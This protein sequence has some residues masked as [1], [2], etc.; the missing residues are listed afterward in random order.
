MELVLVYKP[1]YNWVAPSWM[2]NDER[3]FL[4]SEK[5]WPD[6]HMKQIWIS[7][8]IIWISIQKFWYSY[9]PTVFFLSEK[10]FI[11]RATRCGFGKCH[12]PGARCD[13]RWRWDFGKDSPHAAGHHWKVAS[14][15]GGTRRPRG[16]RGQGWWSQ[17][18][19][20][21]DIFIGNTIRVDAWHGLMV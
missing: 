6:L 13:D 14:V 19:G 2:K 1:T 15:L 18:Q 3:F 11:Q 12:G 17:G 5:S 8:K 20:I 4:T 16:L 9:E 7:I 21:A 10:S